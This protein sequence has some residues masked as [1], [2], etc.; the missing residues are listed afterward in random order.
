MLHVAESG[1]FGARG[2][3]RRKK[4]F[5]ANACANGIRSAVGADVRIFFFCCIKYFAYALWV[6]RVLTRGTVFGGDRRC[7]AGGLG[8]SALSASCMLFDLPVVD[9]HI[10]IPPY[11]VRVLALF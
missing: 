4:S 9:Y 3:C 5:G 10:I 7:N 1:T 11:R 8:S 6:P 2:G